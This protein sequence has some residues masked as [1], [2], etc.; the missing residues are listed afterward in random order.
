MTTIHII[1][2][3]LLQLLTPFYITCPNKASRYRCRH[4]YHQ[5]TLNTLAM[6]PLTHLV[7]TPAHTLSTQLVNPTY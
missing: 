7:N 2:S 6:H 4:V 3:Y 5:Y 1:P